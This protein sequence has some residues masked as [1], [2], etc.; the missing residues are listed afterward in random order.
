[1]IPINEALARLRRLSIRG[2]I[3]G[4]EEGGRRE[5]SYIHLGQSGRRV[6]RWWWFN[7]EIEIGFGLKGDLVLIFWLWLSRKPD[8][9]EDSVRLEFL[10][11]I[12]R[13]THTPSTIKS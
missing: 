3:V 4:G 5:E 2:V 7:F 13:I 6:S 1:M 9:T 12:C 10:R 8:W 11:I